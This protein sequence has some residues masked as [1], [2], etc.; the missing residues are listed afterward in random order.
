MSLCE[1]RL[2]RDRSIEE[3]HR[4]ML[5]AMAAIRD[6]PRLPARSGTRGWARSWFT[7]ATRLEWSMG[8]GVATRDVADSVVFLLE[9]LAAATS[10]VITL[11]HG[12]E[13]SAELAEAVGA[14]VKAAFPAQQVELIAGGQPYYPYILACQ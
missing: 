12:A 8:T 4:A 2:P 1:P 11:Y 7:R 3:N 10:E 5:E 13:V 6:R 14:R 9:K